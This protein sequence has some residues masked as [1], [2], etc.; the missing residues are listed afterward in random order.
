MPQTPPPKPLFNSAHP[1]ARRDL[2][3]GAAALGIAAA[4][5]SLPLLAFAATT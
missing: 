5:A 2:L 3:V 1:I 4:T